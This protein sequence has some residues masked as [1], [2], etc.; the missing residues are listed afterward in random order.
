M[1]KVPSLRISGKT[2]KSSTPNVSGRCTHGSTASGCNWP[3]PSLKYILVIID[4]FT[5][6]VEAA[7]IAEQS[8]EI[9]AKK[10]VC[11]FIARFGAPLEI[12]TDQGHNFESELFAE[13]CRL[14]QVAKTWTTPYH[15]S[16]NG[17]VESFK[18]TLLGMVRCYADE[19]QRNWDE[20]LLLLTAA[21]RSSPHAC[22]GFTP[23]R[24]MLGREVHQTHDVSL[25]VT[26]VNV[27]RKSPVEFV[28]NLE[29][30]NKNKSDT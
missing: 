2:R 28:E 20:Y 4:Q 27:T 7:P 17:Q 16:S 18:R 24:M 30:Q 6:W 13:V 11:E 1:S 15:P 25:G 3:F 26:D 9:T 14:L 10:L 8:A 19:N 23:N 29:E 12:F 5:R 21:Y 22:T